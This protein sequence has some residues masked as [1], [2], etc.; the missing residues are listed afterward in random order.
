MCMSKVVVL[1]Y[2][3]D[4]DYR[5]IG[6]HTPLEDF[7]LAFF[8]NSCFN[9]QLKRF[10]DDL[11]FESSNAH[12][13]LFTYDCQQTFSSW[14]LIS[15]K[16]HYISKVAADSNLFSEQPQTS[17]LIREKSKVDYFLKIE[18]DFTTREVEDIVTKIN[19]IR[20][21]LTSYSMNPKS[22]KSKDFLI[23]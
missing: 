19:A 7:R 6:L 20:S 1:N 5:L 10:D 12:F 23:F 16:Y 21:V 18:A 17:V 14:S 8:L 15:N 22:L 11:D 2:Q 4:H 13:S 9:I 3:N